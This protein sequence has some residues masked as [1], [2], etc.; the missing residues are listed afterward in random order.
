LT[1]TVPTLGSDALGLDR[2]DPSLRHFLDGRLE[3]GGTIL[4]VK[5]A[6]GGWLPQRYETRW[7]KTSRSWVRP[8][9][10]P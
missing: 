7:V 3:E 8:A 9:S 10:A 6:D 4:E 2:T 5:L 1:E